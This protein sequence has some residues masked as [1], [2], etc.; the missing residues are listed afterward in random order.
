MHIPRLVVCKDTIHYKYWTNLREWWGFGI[1]ERTS[2]CPYC[3]FMLWFTLL[4][5]LMFPFAILGW[6]G[7]RKPISMC[8]G[9]KRSFLPYP[10][11]PK[12]YPPFIAN[13]VGT[14]AVLLVALVLFAVGALCGVITVNLSDI[15][16]ALGA[17]AKGVGWA[18]V[19]VGWAVVYAAAHI[20][21][22]GDVAL[23]GIRWFFTNENIWI[24]VGSVAGALVCGI[25]FSFLGYLVITLIADSRFVKPKLD[26]IYNVGL[27]CLAFLGDCVDALWERVRRRQW[28]ALRHSRRRKRTETALRRERR[29]QRLFRWDAKFEARKERRQRGPGF[30]ARS[31]TGVSSGGRK[32]G[33]GGSFVGSF[34]GFHVGTGAWF[35][36]GKIGSGASFVGSQIGR[37]AIRARDELVGKDAIVRK[38]S[39]K[40]L[41]VGLL[42]WHYIVAVKKGVCPMLEFA[43]ADEVEDK[44]VEIE[45]EK[46]DPFKGLT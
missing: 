1:P 22:A 42:V 5:I 33:N 13:M 23:E 2:L 12:D 36:G 26:K 37:G 35:L 20:W 25:G 8:V 21:Y 43:T 19:Y 6:I 16:G 30:W 40:M 28:R 3:Q 15:A 9:G 41:G 29:R 34:V 17:A 38:G 39:V 18:V 27:E 45:M 11:D 46:P 24:P 44:L 31:W 10:G 32:I 14:S 7:L 4:R